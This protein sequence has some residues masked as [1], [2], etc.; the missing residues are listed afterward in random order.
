V[1]RPTKIKNP[2]ATD[3]LGF[4]TPDRR[5]R[6]CAHE[7]ALNSRLSPSSYLGI[8]HISDPQGGLAEPVIVMRRYPD[9]SRWSSATA[10]AMA[11]PQPP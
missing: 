3:F 5:E 6:A 9:A 8:A 1:T 2:I 10:S 4:S 11:W 7:V